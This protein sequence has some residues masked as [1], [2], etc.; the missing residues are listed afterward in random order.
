MIRRYV[1]EGITVNRCH[2]PSRLYPVSIGSTS[3]QGRSTG[4]PSE[5]LNWRPAA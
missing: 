1:L 3:N 4:V 2:R 5:T